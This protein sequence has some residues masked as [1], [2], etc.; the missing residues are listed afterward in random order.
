[1]SIITISIFQCLQRDHNVKIMMIAKGGFVGAFNI[2]YIA[3]VSKLAGAA[4]GPITQ[5]LV[6]AI[7]G[8]NIQLA[9][10]VHE[11]DDRGD[12]NDNL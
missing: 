5:R 12:F 8:V 1:M 2:F 7:Q 11:S 9:N 4:P 10:F 6:Y 3:I